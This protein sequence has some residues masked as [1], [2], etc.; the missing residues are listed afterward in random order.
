MGLRSVPRTVADG[1]CCAVT[2]ERKE[3]LIHKAKS[4]NSI[5]QIPVP[6]AISRTF[7]GSVR[8]ARCSLSSIVMTNKLC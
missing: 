6:V 3:S 1:Y 5:A 7:W 2:N 4:P 8:G